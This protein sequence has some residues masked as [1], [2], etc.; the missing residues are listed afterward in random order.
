MWTLDNLVSK[1]ETWRT[2]EKRRI[3]KPLRK[4][5]TRKKLLR[6]RIISKA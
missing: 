2:G 3:R 4:K 6:K 1:R 5:K